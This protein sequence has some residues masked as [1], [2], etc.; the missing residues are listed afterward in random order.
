MADSIII[1]LDLQTGDTRSTFNKIE[2]DALKSGK[3]SGSSFGN[4]FSKSF[5]KTA[6]DIL[7]TTAKIT[8]A[9]GSIAS[10]L[11]FRSSIIAAQQQEDAINQL[12][13]ALQ[14]TGKFSEQSS[15]ELQNY[16]SSLQQITRFGDEAILSAQGL[17]QS[18]GNLSTDQLKQATAATLDLAAALKIDL[19]TAALLVGKAAAGE[20]GTFSRYGLSIKKAGDN[21]KTFANALDAIQ[22]KFGG[23]AQK[24]V[25]TFSGATQQLSNTFGDL[26]EEIGFIITKN[27]II[28]NGLSQLNKLFQSA[29]IRVR[30]FAKTFSLIDDVITPLLSVGDA[31]IQYVIRPF[32]LVGNVG[33]VAF[34]ILELGVASVVNAFAKLGGIVARVFQALGVDNQLTQ[35]LVNFENNTLQG[36]INKSED[37]TKAIA[38]IG[39]TSF[40]D[41]LSQRNQELQ[42][43]FA[44]QQAIINEG[45]LNATTVQTQQTEVAK[46]SLLGLSDVFGT[47][48][49]GINTT[50]DNS[51]Q[52]I[53]EVND[54]VKKFSQEAANS[55]RQGIATGAGQAFASFGAALVKGE[56]ALEAFGKTLLKTIADQAVALGTKF[57]LEGAAYAFLPGYQAL[58]APLIAAGAALAAFGGALG[59][60]I[61]GSGGGASGGGGGSPTTQNTNDFLVEDTT[62]P[63]QVERQ[64]PQQNVEIVVQG[65]L[66]QQEELGKFIA[67]TLTDVGAKNGISVFNTRFA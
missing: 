62:A 9:V 1:Q 34:N 33:N 31:I 25:L 58:S 12:N 50:I 39:D 64:A 10:A 60:T 21:A 30:D 41:N 20:V 48:F 26:L 66:V 65:S 22:G 11:T 52:K 19:N 51:Q 4:N 27:P 36:V 57:I 15:K 37:V 56:N 6:S 8:A 44:E 40:S 7:K 3:K 43:Y 32:E 38:K 2:Q 28:L 53:K 14:I 45:A 5:Q 59:A 63:T 16:A 42:T 67:D 35:F 47:V 18:L 23:A 55:L 29:I 17:I 46:Q 61:G 54:R 13:T 24:E 49:S